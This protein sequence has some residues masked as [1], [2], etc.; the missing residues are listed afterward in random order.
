MKDSLLHYLRTASTYTLVDSLVALPSPALHEKT[1]AVVSGSVINMRTRPDDAA[2]MA[3]QAILGTPLRVL[4]RHEEWYLVQTPD[5]YL[6][7][8]WDIIALM[9][10][11]EFARWTSLPKV[12]VTAM[13]GFVHESADAS[14]RPVSDVVAGSLFAVLGED[15]KFYSVQYPDGRTGW[16][17]RT[18]AQPYTDWLSHASDTPDNVISTAYRFTGIPYLWGGTSAKALD[19]SGFVKTVFFLNGVLL[20]AMQASRPKWGL[21]CR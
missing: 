15:S 3:S 19:C 17:E 5:R 10:G 6:G 11:Q 2:E 21:M 16:L 7:W 9:T 1:F 4:E 8:T 14:S 13:F 18:A 12:I 20:P